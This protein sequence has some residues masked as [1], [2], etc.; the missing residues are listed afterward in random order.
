MIRIV[1][2]VCQSK[3]NA[4]DELAGQS[5]KC[6]KCGN[7]LS[8]PRQSGN[9]RPVEEA[10]PPVESQ[11]NRAGPLPHLPVPERLVRTNRYLILDREKVF[12]L[13]ETSRDGWQLKI[14]EGYIN[15]ARNPDKLPN[16]GEYV[17]VELVM[18]ITDHG[19]RLRGLA[20][21]KLASHWA[22]TT[23][24]QGDHRIL[25][26][27]VGPGSLN[28]DQKTAVRDFLGKELMYEVLKDCA[29][30]LGF[31]GQQRFSLPRGG[32]CDDLAVASPRLSLSS[33]C[34][35]RRGRRGGRRP[36]ETSLGGPALARASLS[37][38]ARRLRDRDLLR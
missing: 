33:T 31:P 6:P 20:C 17:L 36:T 29:S 3:L 27:I 23:L 13:W 38:P 4:K 35:L 11:V 8:I 7:L 14:R 18:S 5:R 1:C 24:S 9:S 15:A 37:H 28:R 16:L 30:G 21:Y 2:P 32:R 34:R 19:L 25:T 22:L 12:A 26:R 10:T